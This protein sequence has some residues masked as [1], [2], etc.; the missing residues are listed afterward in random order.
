MRNMQIIGSPWKW[1]AAALL[2]DFVRTIGGIILTAAVVIGIH[3][4]LNSGQP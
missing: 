2:V 3:L 1:A 4:A